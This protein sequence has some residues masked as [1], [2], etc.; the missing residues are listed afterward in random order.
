MTEISSTELLAIRQFAR[1]TS[2]SASFCMSHVER[3]VHAYLD[4]QIENVR[5]HQRIKF[6]EE[7]ARDDGDGHTGETR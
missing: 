6:L 2:E 1:S 4:I 3:L 7:S 5:L